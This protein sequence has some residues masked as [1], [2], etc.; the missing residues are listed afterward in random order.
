MCKAEFDPT[1]LN[2]AADSNH[3]FYI[4]GKASFNVN[5]L[6]KL[7]ASIDPKKVRQQKI[8]HVLSSRNKE[9]SNVQHLDDVPIE[10]LPYMLGSIQQ[11][12]EYHAG[13]NTPPKHDK[14]VNALSVVYETMRR[15]DK[16]FSVY[17]SL[18]R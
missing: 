4:V 9:C 6:N 3:T 11:Y 15:W 2:T 8:Y 7:S 13:E 14:D 12:S 18:S 10:F 17:E 16:A 5:P 1:S